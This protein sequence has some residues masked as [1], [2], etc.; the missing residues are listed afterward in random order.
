M[1]K[2]DTESQRPIQQ[3]DN[4]HHVPVINANNFSQNLNYIHPKEPTTAK[5]MQII[6]L[7]QQTNLSMKK[8][9]VPTLAVGVNN[10]KKIA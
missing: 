6:H 4:M 3:Q 2:Y 1:N 9:Y 10:S 8:K 5:H 7:E